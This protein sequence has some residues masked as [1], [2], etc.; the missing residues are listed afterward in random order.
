M[1]DLRVCVTCMCVCVCVCVC[2]LASIPDT[3][4]GKNLSFL[5]AR[6]RGYVCVCVCMSTS[7]STSGV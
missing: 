3:Q 1:M 5:N 4:W 2:V 6:E 7:I